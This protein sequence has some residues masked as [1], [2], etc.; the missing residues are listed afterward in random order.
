VFLHLVGSAGH[1]IHSSAYGVPNVNALFFLLRWDRY[2]LHKKRAETR[3][4]KLVILR[5]VGSAGHVEH[6][7]ASGARNVDVQFFMLG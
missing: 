2:E 3:Y 7:C 4:V 5:P 1:I 6:S